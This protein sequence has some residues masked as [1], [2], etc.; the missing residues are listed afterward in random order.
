MLSEAGVV[1]VE[2]MAL[3][4][5]GMEGGVGRKGEIGFAAWIWRGEGSDSSLSSSLWSVFR[6]LGLA[7]GLTKTLA[8]PSSSPRR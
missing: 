6:A 2:V 7:L 1:V 3:D 8:L 5:E 4:G